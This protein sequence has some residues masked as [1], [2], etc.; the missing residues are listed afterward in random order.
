[1]DIVP[2]LEEA[3]IDVLRHLRENFKD[4][5]SIWVQRAREVL[6]RLE[7][8]R[9]TSKDAEPVAC[10][11]NLAKKIRDFATNNSNGN[12]YFR[13][14]VDYTAENI[15]Q[16]V[17]ETLPYDAS[18]ASVA[19]EAP[20]I[21]DELAT[22]I[23]FHALIDIRGQP[24]MDTQIV[25]A[26]QE[27]EGVWGRIKSDIAAQVQDV[28]GW[29]EVPPET[30]IEEATKGKRV[31]AY[32]KGRYYNA[33]LEFEASEGGWLWFDDADSEPNPS[34]WMPLP[35]APAANQGEAG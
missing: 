15:A 19:E 35:A 3:L 4:D 33:W 21:T 8:V 10:N 22:D 12:S 31:L 29:Q 1:M 2:A 23:I 18:S 16:M 28:A 20:P 13:D 32:E 9:T 11:I 24:F 27:C 5:D 6:A 34:H 26:M 25:E 7:Q 17:E 30:V 14:G